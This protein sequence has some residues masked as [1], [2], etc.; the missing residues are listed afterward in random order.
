[1][2][3]DLVSKEEFSP[4]LAREVFEDEEIGQICSSFARN[5]SLD[6]HLPLSV[7]KLA[8]QMEQNR[9]AAM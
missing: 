4:S 3:L 6:L 8:S 7:E 1:M 2:H 9:P 5:A